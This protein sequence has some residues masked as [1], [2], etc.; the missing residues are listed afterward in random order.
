[1][2]RYCEREVSWQLLK[3]LY[4]SVGRVG[5]FAAVSKSELIVATRLSFND[6]PFAT[7]RPGVR[8]PSRPPDSGGPT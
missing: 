5:Q 1:M 3:R 8:I 7:R 4:D 2:R 6:S